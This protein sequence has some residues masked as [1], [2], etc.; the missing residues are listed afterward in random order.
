MPTDLVIAGLPTLA[1]DA[2]RAQSA[3]RFAPLGSLFVRPLKTF[4]YPRDHAA[5]YLSQLERRLSVLDESVPVS[6]TVAFVDFGDESSRSFMS[7]FYPF[8]LVCPIR[9]LVINES[10]RKSVQ[11]A[12]ISNYVQYL[13]SEV[14]RLRRN[15]AIISEQTHIHNISPLV[16][17]AKNFS[18]RHY[19]AM[20]D[21]L[22]RGLGG[23]L[24]PHILLKAALA[25]FLRHHPR[26]NAGTDR[27]SCYSD[28]HLYFGSP[29]NHR[30]GYFRNG[31]SKGHLSTCLLNARSRLGGS[32][33]YNFHYDC[34]AV[35][36]L[37]SEY[38][39]CHGQPKAPNIKHINI[40]PNDYII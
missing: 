5:A 2:V 38:P 10:D 29:G 17:P 6:I 35:T 14:A 22:F 36:K 37:N 34:T 26:A 7:N 16:L 13:I 33:S 30:H 27:K 24:D 23:A 40:A 21:G 39:D 3:K 9:P 20:I 4:G 8:A 28:G 31:Q 25:E 18:S 19:R 12:A 15:A 32:V 11:S 1:F